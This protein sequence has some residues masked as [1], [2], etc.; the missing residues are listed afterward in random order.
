MVGLL[1]AVPLWAGSPSA[2]LAAANKRSA[3]RRRGQTRPGT[4]EQ[5]E[6]RG[7]RSGSRIRS[8]QLSE[9]EKPLCGILWAE[10][11]AFPGTRTPPES[12]NKV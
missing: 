2:A 5:V 12:V 4:P 10:W 3:A 1:P 7:R 8:K 9:W 6:R 11:R